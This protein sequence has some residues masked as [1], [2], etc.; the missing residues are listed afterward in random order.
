MTESTGAI[1]WAIGLLAAD[2]TVTGLVST[3]VYDSLAPQDTDEPYIIIQQQAYS[4]D[5]TSIAG[6]IG[7]GRMM[8]TVKAVTQSAGFA[9][10][11]AIYKAAHAA[12]QGQTGNVSGAIIHSCIRDSVIR[13]PEISRGV[14]YNHLGGVYRMFVSP[15]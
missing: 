5:G 7:A 3:R 9:S 4:E 8:L 6:D 12:I 15:A 1:A 2:A 14:R 13:Y 11:E 10:A